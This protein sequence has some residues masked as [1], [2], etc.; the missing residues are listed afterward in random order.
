MEENSFIRI[1]LFGFFVF[2]YSANAKEKEVPIFKVVSSRS[3]L[4]PPSIDVLFPN[5]HRDEFVLENYKLFK[6]SNGGHKYIGYLKNTPSSSVAVTGHLASPSDRMEITLLSD[7]TADQMFEVDYF[8]RTEIIPVPEKSSMKG[9]SKPSNRKYTVQDEDEVMDPDKQKA[10]YATAVEPMPSKL[11]MVMKFG[12]TEGLIIQ[13]KKER[14][15]GQADRPEKIEDFIENVMAHAQANFY[16][17]TL[18]TRITLEAKE[19]LLYS[20]NVSWYAES[21][22]GDA[23]VIA[24]AADP[25]ANGVD[26]TAWLTTGDYSVVG[27]AY[28]TSLCDSYAVSITEVYGKYANTGHVLAHETGHNMGMGHDSSHGSTSPCNLEDAGTMGS[29][30]IRWSSCSRYAFEHAYAEEFWGHGC[31]EDISR[32]CTKD[33][34]QNG[35]TCTETKNGGFSCSCPAGVSGDRCESNPNGCNG[36]DDCCTSDN[37]CGEWDGDCDSDS[38]CLDGLACGD[39]NCPVKYGGVDWEVGDD[40]CFKPKESKEN[41]ESTPMDG[42][43]KSGTCVFPFYYKGVEYPYCAKPDLYNDV[44]FCSFDT[45]YKGNWGYCTDGCPK[46]PTCNAVSYDCP[47]IIGTGPEKKKPGSNGKCV[48]PFKYDGQMNYK[49]R[50]P[51]DYAG[52]GWCAFDS[53]MEGDR[54]GYC[55][56]ECPKEYENVENYTDP[57]KVPGLIVCN[58]PGETCQ[59][60]VCKCGTAC[61]CEGRPTGSYCDADNSIC[62]CSDTED[63]CEEGSLCDPSDKKCR[64]CIGGSSCC[65][66]DNKCDAMEGDCDKDEECKDGLKCGTDNCAQCLEG[67]GPADGC[68]KWAYNTDCCYDP[69]NMI[70]I[71]GD[72]CCSKEYPCGLGEGDCDNDNECEGELKCGTDNCQQ[73]LGGVDCTYF[74]PTDD[75]CEE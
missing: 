1:I 35:G 69:A 15:N 12:Y 10:V 62:K 27:M 60:G 30:D 50:D 37:K 18:G 75:C 61:S 9:V 54:W 44:G 48:F 34:C 71:G 39:N 25:T 28:M 63:A 68:G 58:V 17:P 65:T 49:C 45:V 36:V 5:G 46:I 8:G 42:K 26:V 38:D 4:E 70:C 52:V 66:T 51:K 47:P 56:P 2:G 24:N 14:E 23:R 20:S 57:C 72:E 74:Q 13:M 40:C 73:C 3:N 19:G 67:Q 16:D 55:T 53:V 11:K 64:K 41:C 33:T 31:L 43:G 29:G 59:D 7:H 21:N 32:P 6:G 22:L